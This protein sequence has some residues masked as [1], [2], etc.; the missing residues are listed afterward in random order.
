[1]KDIVKRL[2]NVNEESLIMAVVSDCMDAA[3]EIQRLRDENTA[4]AAS[5]KK[6]KK[7]VHKNT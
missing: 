4:M 7:T 2:K 3:E 6:I 1:V 5:L